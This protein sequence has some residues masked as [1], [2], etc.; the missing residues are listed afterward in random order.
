MQRA[1]ADEAPVE[2][3]VEAPVEVHH[4]CLGPD[5]SEGTLSLPPKGLL[6]GGVLG[7]ARLAASLHPPVSWAGDK[8]LWPSQPLLSLRDSC[9]DHAKISRVSPG[10][11]SNLDCPKSLQP[12]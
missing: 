12:T 2:A 1:S 8:H 9:W 3:L 6:G 4:V 7:C 11:P 5:H 10:H